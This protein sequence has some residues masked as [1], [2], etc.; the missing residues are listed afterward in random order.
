MASREAVR[1]QR[2][3]NVWSNDL[4]DVFA[5]VAPYYDRANNIA[6]LGMFGRFLRRFMQLVD[7]KP[8]QKVLDVCAGTNAIGIALLKREPTLDVHAMDRSVAM[9]TVGQQRAT[10]QGFKI[11]STIGDVHK[12][13]FPDNHFDVVTLQFAS[14]HLRVREVFTEILRVLKPGGHFHHS[15]MLRPRN[16]IVKK[17]YHT[18]LRGCL[19]LTGLIVGSGPAAF[20]AKQYF[21]DALELFYTAEELSIL[22]GEL[23]YVEVTVDTVFYGMLGFHRAAKPAKS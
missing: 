18:Y 8:K 17:L 1:E 5:D 19:G 6:A 21:L 3:S 20:K 10:A 4:N 23:G 16:I 14:R 11:K 15:D 7:L 2:F 9:Q 22:L 12:L 13:P